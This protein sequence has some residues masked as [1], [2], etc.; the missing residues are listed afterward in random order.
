M[1]VAHLQN[2]LSRNHSSLTRNTECKRHNDSMLQ[3]VCLLFHLIDPSSFHSL[4]TVKCI[5]YTKPCIP[6]MALSAP[7]EDLMIGHLQP[8]S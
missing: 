7:E 5:I 1:P 4:K 2:L 8:P 6:I 3:V